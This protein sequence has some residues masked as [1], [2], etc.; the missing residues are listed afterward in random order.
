MMTCIGNKRKLL[1]F[2]QSVV[3][4]VVKRVHAPA[5]RKLRVMDA[6][7]GSG[8]V[9]R[10]LLSY[11][12]LLITNDQE[13][14]A[15]LLSQ[16]VFR[17]P[18][19]SDRKRVAAHISRINELPPLV[20]VVAQNYAPAQTKDVQPGERAFFSQ[21]NA[22]RIDAARAYIQN[23]V[24][25]RLQPYCMG[26]LLIQASIHCN[27]CGV[28][29]GFYK[30]DGVGC[31]GGVGKH[32]LPR[33]LGRIVLEMPVWHG[34]GAETRTL[35]GD[36]NEVMRGPEVPSNLDLIY[37]DPPYNQH[38]YGSNYFMLNVIMDQRPTLGDV[39]TVSGI[40]Q[41]WLRSAYNK[42][43]RA[44][45]SMKEL[46]AI[47]LTKARFVLLSYNDEGIIPVAGWERL[48]AP[49]TV[50]RF[51]QTYEAFK[52]SR[53]RKK[54]RNTVQEVLY[55]LQLPVLPKAVRCE[56]ESRGDTTD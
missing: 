17:C 54:R 13:P 36:T 50:E 56:S 16:C 27:T 25:P 8:V 15:H 51:E 30:A 34:G 3:E 37:L 41:G 19:A 5:G 55:L 47:C 18:D 20:G 40:P 2:I 35:R 9:G 10:L 49:Y 52:G 44:E 45:A 48:L 43:G 28:F 38:P 23:E 29:K 24:E 1:P 11:A 14:Y 21:E 46:L 26:P 53:N 33:I 32:S 42:R 7:T 31:F 12:E 22:C 6:F 39:S 4:D